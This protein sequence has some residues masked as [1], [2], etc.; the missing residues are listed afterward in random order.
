MAQLPPIAYLDKPYTF[1]ISPDTFQFQI[2][3]NAQAPPSASTL[4]YSAASLP[5]W[6]AFD[7]N[8]LTFT[9]TAPAQ[10][11]GQTFDISVTGALQEGTPSLGGNASATNSLSLLVLNEPAV[12]V[13]VPITQQLA[14][15]SSL[16]PSYMVAPDAIHLPLGWSF[17][18]GL[19]GDTFAIATGADVFWSASLAGGEALP[20][21]LHFDPSSYDFY[22]VAPVDNETKKDEYDVV[23][24]GS[25]RAGYGGATQTFKLVVS[26]K[27]LSLA[28]GLQTVN[29]SI[30]QYLQ[31]VVPTDSLRLNGER[32]AAPDNVTVA[33]TVSPQLSWLKFD[34]NNK[35]LSGVPP[36]EPYGNASSTTTVSVPITFADGTGNRLTVNQ[37]ISI[38]PSLF[39]ALELPNLY[40]PDGNYV[41]VSIKSFL[42]NSTT[43]AKRSRSQRATLVNRAPVSSPNV[44]VTTDPADASSWLKY[45]PSSMLLSGQVPSDWSKRIK[46]NLS[47]QGPGNE[48]SNSSF[49]LTFNGDSDNGD[50]SNGS[51]DGAGGEGLSSKARV[52]LGASLGAAAGIA[53]LLLLLVCCRRKKGQDER[54]TNGFATTREDDEG[55]LTDNGSGGR[56]KWKK[57]IVVGRAGVGEMG[58]PSTLAASP[59]PG[60]DE[61]QA[62]TTPPPSDLHSVVV[63][64][65]NGRRRD[66][67]HEA[68]APMQ[69]RLIANLFG[70]HHGPSDG[71]GKKKRNKTPNGTGLGLSLGGTDEPDPFAGPPSDSRGRIRHQR[72]RESVN[73]RRSSWE[74]DLFYEDATSTQPHG[75]PSEGHGLPIPI[76][77]DDVPRRRGKPSSRSAT[78]L[79]VRHRNTHIN[80]S[81]AFNAPGVFTPASLPAASSS[82]SLGNTGMTATDSGMSTLEGDDYMDSQT[83][84]TPSREDDTRILKARV[85]QVQRHSPILHQGHTNPFTHAATR[86]GDAVVGKSYDAYGGAF[87]D[88]EDDEWPGMS[89]PARKASRPADDKRNSALSTMTDASH[90]AGVRAHLANEAAMEAAADANTPDASF[91]DGA[92]ISGF[93]PQETMKAVK[94][95]PRPQTPP[96]RAAVIDR[97][98][99]PQ[100]P[101]TPK[102]AP[103]SSGSASG[104][105][106]PCPT[107][108]AVMGN[109][110]RFHLYPNVPP[111][112]AGAPGSPGKR[113]GRTVRYELVML[114]DR[115]HLAKYFSQ[116]PAMLADWLSIN[117]ATFE[118]EGIVP[119]AAELEQLGDCEIALISTTRISGNANSPDRQQNK[120]N[121]TSSHDSTGRASASNDEE[122]T[123]VARARLVFQN[124]APRAFMPR[125][126]Q[127][128]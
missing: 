4:V 87:D 52:A 67:T 21:W 84:F 118:V 19:R 62:R 35:T 107:V 40:V 113:S 97:K 104:R 106:L 98:A 79:N 43:T 74:S 37:K 100:T 34:P 90:L 14:S 72:S 48:S 93:D 23:I 58:T 17:S 71:Q 8:S 77:E 16:G 75:E 109:L 68:E 11:T 111:P 61:K 7:A 78:G 15:A 83:G 33:A 112:M 65:P 38:P 81:P 114:D 49:Y 88:A 117:V 119:R 103:G 53:A 108:Q 31:T 26:S 73:S 116:W 66:A 13:K 105:Q 57:A 1:T 59:L 69:S 86:S 27:T 95:G 24:T 96:A 45:D 28:Q 121:S 51:N 102:R 3:R 10:D 46:V 54:S 20:E 18:V 94:P 56:R 55:T 64:S 76:G 82:Q 80:E 42:R 127:A 12:T 92:S 41:N 120:R 101:K 91:M 125:H 110:L 60:Y 9:G 2:P 32:E 63:V 22:G 29:A 44:T 39:T 30:G 122:R 47:A 36:Y 123:V 70:N 5:P 99:G 85:M 89:A 115:P 126:G 6:L 50:P 128:F 25:N 124:A